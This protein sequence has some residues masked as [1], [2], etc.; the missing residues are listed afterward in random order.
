VCTVLASFACVLNGIAEV[1]VA[2]ENTCRAHWTCEKYIRCTVYVYFQSEEVC[3]EMCCSFFFLFSGWSQQWYYRYSCALLT[4][5]SLHFFSFQSG[6]EVCCIVFL[7]VGRSISSPGERQIWCG[8]ENMA[9]HCGKF[10]SVQLEKCEW[11]NSPVQPFISLIEQSN[12]DDSMNLF[13]RWPTRSSAKTVA[14]R[15]SFIAAIGFWRL[16]K[17]ITMILLYKYLI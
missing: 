17:Q 1:H 4:C 8:T 11:F 16:L 10:L 13:T 12:L 2:L 14:L 5:A 15:H 7:I 3:N 9:A 6:E